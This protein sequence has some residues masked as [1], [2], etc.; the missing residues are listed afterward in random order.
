[1]KLNKIQLTND[2]VENYK[3]IIKHTSMPINFKLQH[4]TSQNS[5]AINNIIYK[6]N[7]VVKEDYITTSLNNGD[8]G[9]FDGSS[10]FENYNDIEYRFLLMN[11]VT[12]MYI[13]IGELSV[14]TYTWNNNISTEYSKAGFH[15]LEP[16]TNENY[17]GSTFY[18]T[19]SAIYPAGS[20]MVITITSFTNNELKG[21][22]SGIFVGKAGATIKSYNITE[23]QFYLPLK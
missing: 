10:I 3:T 17:I 12:T 11:A 1:M 23:G 16:Q 9:N 22:F 21:T 20:S 7:K 4:R 6:I 19:S 2:K 13:P 15:Y 8:I 14:K 18:Y 5:T